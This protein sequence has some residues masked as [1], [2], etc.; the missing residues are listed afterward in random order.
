MRNVTLWSGNISGESTGAARACAERR[1]DA[2]SPTGNIHRRI[3]SREAFLSRATDGHARYCEGPRT[4]RKQRESSEQLQADR[5]GPE[6]DSN[7]ASVAPTF[8]NSTY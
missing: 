1:V 7:T 2:H 8:Q 4:S 5:E 6:R 3:Y